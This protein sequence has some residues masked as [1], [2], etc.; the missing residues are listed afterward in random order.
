MLK[1]DLGTEMPLHCL[2]QPLCETGNLVQMQIKLSQQ[3]LQ[4]V[5]WLCQG[6]ACQIQHPLMSMQK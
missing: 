6:F 1:V 5:I 2:A 4:N 3:D